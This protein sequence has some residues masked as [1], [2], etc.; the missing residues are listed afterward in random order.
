MATRSTIALEYVDG[1][2]DQIYCH[3]DGYLSHNGK[4]LMEHWQDPFKVQEMM[5]LG[6]LSILGEAIGE[7][8][9]FD[10]DIDNHVCTFYGRDRGETDIGAKRFTNFQDYVENHQYEEFEYILR[11]DGQW[12]VSGDSGDYVLLS[13][14]LEQQVA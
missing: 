4:I 12:Y 9:D 8:H 11:N 10:D 7:K 13:V 2:V 5:D 3:W 6:A 14:A 1:T